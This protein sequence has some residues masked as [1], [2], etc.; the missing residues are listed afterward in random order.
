MMLVRAT[1]IQMFSCQIISQWSDNVLA[2]GPVDARKYNKQFSHYK[3]DTDRTVRR[4][5]DMK[6]IF[7]FQLK[8]ILDFFFKYVNV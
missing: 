8:N 7:P 2:L 3:E 5:E 6:F 1:T 4:Q